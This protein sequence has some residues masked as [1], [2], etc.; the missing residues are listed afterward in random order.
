MMLYTELKEKETGIP[1]VIRLN[2]HTHRT[3][4]VCTR[5]A[6]YQPVDPN[7]VCARFVF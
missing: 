6:F 5:A 1:G 4:H 3:V 7:L 2:S